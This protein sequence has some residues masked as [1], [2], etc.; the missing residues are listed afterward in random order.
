MNEYIVK[1]DKYYY[2]G[3]NEYNVRGYLD[4]QHPTKTI[5]LT[6]FDFKALAL[7]EYEDAV[8]V[9][10]RCKNLGEK[11]EILTIKK[12]VTVD[13]VKYFRS[14]KYLA[15]IL[16]EEQ[17]KTP[18]RELQKELNIQGKTYYRILNGF[19]IEVYDRIIYNV[20]AELL[21]RGYKEVELYLQRRRELE[22]KKKKERGWI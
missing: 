22:Y 19:A 13:T 14:D 9:A 3:T 12:S 17:K 2:A 4:K 15:D 6:K 7:D 18:Q 16:K 8:E 20:G 10:E 5:K 1:I 21:K 11:I